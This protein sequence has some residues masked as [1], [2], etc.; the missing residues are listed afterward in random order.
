M[1]HRS[2]DPKD[3]PGAIQAAQDI[4][5]SYAEL[6]SMNTNFPAPGLFQLDFEEA[7]FLD[8]ATGLATVRGAIS[9]QHVAELV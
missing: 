5:I 7:A 4:S 3:N 1:V 6:D 9:P 2:A 8:H